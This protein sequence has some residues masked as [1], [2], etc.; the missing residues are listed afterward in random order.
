VVATGLENDR[1]ITV[2]VT[3]LAPAD[4]WVAFALR[5]SPGAVFLAAS[6]FSRG[7]FKATRTSRLFQGNV[8]HTPSPAFDSTLLGWRLVR[9]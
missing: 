5:L 6:M 2:V 3:G 4:P 7:A 8:T 1:V 9:R